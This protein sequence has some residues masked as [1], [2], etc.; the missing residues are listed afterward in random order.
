MGGQ[1]IDI[2]MKSRERDR[3]I[4]RIQLIKYIIVLW[5]FIFSSSR[6]LESNLNVNEFGIWTTQQKKIDFFIEWIK[7]SVD[8]FLFFHL[9]LYLYFHYH[10]HHHHHITIDMKPVNSHISSYAIFTIL[11]S[12]YFFFLFYQ[13]NT[14]CQ[15]YKIWIPNTHGNW[16]QNHHH[17][18]HYRQQQQSSI[19]LNKENLF[20]TS[21]S[22]VKLTNGIQKVKKNFNNFKNDKS[23]VSNQFFFI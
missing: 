22:I 23:I 9:F 12:F 11:S 2:M 20:T 3:E 8:W 13:I 4:Y 10:H 7:D 1:T 14:N 5:P 17:H 15:T 6:M 21:I 18:H 19:N 16:R